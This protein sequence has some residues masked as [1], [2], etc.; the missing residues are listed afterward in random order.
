MGRGMTSMSRTKSDDSMRALAELFASEYG[1]SGRITPLG[2]ENENYQLDTSEGCRYVF[3]LADD[4]VSGELIDLEYQI[5]RRIHA[6]SIKLKVPQIVLTRSGKAE[7]RRTAEH[8]VEL[9]GR[10]LEFVPGLS[11]GDAGEPS[12]E[13]LR[14]LGAL[15]GELNIALAEFDH[16]AAHRTNSWDLATATQ[17][18]AAVPLVKDPGR[19]RSLDWALHFFSAAAAPELEELPHSVIHADAND[20]NVLV[21]DGHVR[22]LVDFSDC[23]YNPTVCELAIALAYIMLEKRDPLAVGAEMV[24]GYHQARPLSDMEIAVLPALVCGRLSTTV[25]VAAVRRQINPDH[26]R[27]YVTEERAWCLLE[28]FYAM[29]PVDLALG[30]TTKI[31]PDQCAEPTLPPDELR[32]RRNHHISR[33]LSVAY[34][35]PLCVVRGRGQFLFDDRGRPYLDLVNNVCHVGHCHPRVVE[36]GQKQMAALNTNTRYFYDGLTDYAERLSS[37]LPG[38]LEVCFFVNSGSEANE[39]AL[40]LASAFTGREGLLVLDGGYHGN[41]S[42]MIGSSPYKFR[43][44][45]GQGPGAPTVHVAPMP[46][47]YRGKHKGQGRETGVAYGDEAGRI[48]NET[49]TEFAAF[50]AEPILSCGGQIVPPDG[51]LETAF[52]HARDVGAV[53]IMDEVQVGFGRMGTHFWGFQTQNV[54]PDIVVMGKPIG[55]GH[56]MAAVVTSYE[57]ADA[58][59]NSMEYFS[60]FG[61]NPV[62]CAIGL[63][64]LDVIEEEQLQ[65]RA[66]DL[67]ARLREGLNRLMNEFPL[68]GDV[69]GMGLFQGFELVRSRTTLEPASL[70][71][72]RLVNRMRDRGFLLS[73]DGPLHNV[74]K[75]KPPMVL[76]EDDLD[77]TIRHLR[78]VLSN[79]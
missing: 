21:A 14:E 75:I 20:E 69:R 57:I 4:Q 48:L 53:C 13:L 76:T 36:A 32:E 7:A 56:P 41:T 42:R 25:A 22:G 46:D 9:R 51:F 29:S 74:I 39:L 35:R 28:K 63:A 64:V 47:G 59:A 16:P 54:V 18:R 38:D 43:G 50:L 1:L 26:P 71:A 10:L 15:L 77:M 65:Q 6:S 68:I 34:D 19:Q 40:R 37:T 55:N 33:A 2:G 72:S 79:L 52:Q 5:A 31:R 62:S 60:T 11:V 61:G 8:G 17:H 67:G 3:K 24:A 23:L 12:R 27:W 70:E 58:F 73:T 49:D 45:G 66:L 78:A 30:L 44:E